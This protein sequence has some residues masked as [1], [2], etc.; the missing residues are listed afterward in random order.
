MS[1][2]YMLE[3]YMQMQIIKL[4][5]LL[6]YLNGHKCSFIEMSFKENYINNENSLALLGIVGYY[7]LFFY[8]NTVL[9]LVKR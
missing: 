1:C 9:S 6:F 3:N 4:C 2:I 5:I 7:F 8:Y